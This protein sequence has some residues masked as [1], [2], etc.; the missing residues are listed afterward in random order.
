MTLSVAVV[1]ESSRPA[2]EVAA[3]VEAVNVQVRRDLA[4]WQ[5]YAVVY[6]AGPVRPPPNTPTLF[7]WNDPQQARYA[8][9]LGYHENLKGTGRGHVFVNNAL[10]KKRPW[11]VPGSHELI[12]LLV[13]RQLNSYKL[14][15]ATGELWSVEPADPVDGMAYKINGVEVANFVLPAWYSDEEPGPYDAMGKI[16]HPFSLSAAG[17]ADVIRA[18]DDGH[19]LYGVNQVD[20]EFTRIARRQGDPS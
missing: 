9:S 1:N 16:A 4:P 11:T 14:R 20:S 3:F 2:A 13:D 12:E 10:R 18:G 8:A 17:Y 15:R 19:T 7:L 6:A 5:V